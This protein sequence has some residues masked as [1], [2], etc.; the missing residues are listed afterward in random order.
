MI[1]SMSKTTKDK[2]SQKRQLVLP[3]QGDLIQ[4]S[5]H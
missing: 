5:P 3:K 1:K 4:P 2:K